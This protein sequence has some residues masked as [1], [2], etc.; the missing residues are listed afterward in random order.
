MRREIL[1]ALVVYLGLLFLLSQ[2]AN[3]HVHLGPTP[4]APAA[5]LAAYA[6]GTPADQSRNNQTTTFT[7]VTIAPG[8]YN[9]GQ[10]FNGTTSRMTI[11]TAVTVSSAFT[12]ECWVKL[13]GVTRTIV[14]RTATRRDVG[15]GK[16][17]S[18]EAWTTCSCPRPARS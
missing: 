10:A 3:G 13:T 7:A 1:T 5:L 11:P 16:P 14:G 17:S 18:T 8:R 6:M 15:S 2:S 12:V 9:E 4:A